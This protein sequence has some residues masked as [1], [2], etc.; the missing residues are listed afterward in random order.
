MIGGGD[1]SALRMR[2]ELSAQEESSDSLADRLRA[3]EEAQSSASAAATRSAGD[4]VLRNGECEFSHDAYD[5]SPTVGGDADQL[6]AHWLTHAAATTLLGEADAD[7]VKASGHSAYNAA[8]DDADW[9]RASGRLRLG[10]TK[11]LS[12][13]L[14]NILAQPGGILY[15]QFTATP[16][17]ATALPAGLTFYAGVWDN[18]AGQQKWVSGLALAAT[19]ANGGAA[20]ATPTQYKV[21]VDTDRGE[22]Y[23][24]VMAAPKADAPDA[25]SAVDFVTVAWPAVPGRKTSTVYRSR[26][27]V[28][29]MV[30]VINSGATSWDD[31]GDAGT[32][33]GGF[34][35]AALS[36]LRARVQDNSF[37]PQYGIVTPYRYAI[38]VP[39][40]YAVTNTQEQVLRL[41]LSAA[42]TDARQVILD[43]FQLGLNYGGFQ[44][45]PLDAPVKNRVS[46]TA[47]PTGG[48]QPASNFGDDEPPAPGEGGARRSFE[49][50]P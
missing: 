43:R 11:T 14:T 30:A 45:G 21:I 25:L 26:G 31:F 42:C 17:T 49:I 33:V 20:G 38:K 2:R 6:C 8:T 1:N 37:K 7:T 41:G 32:V 36:A 34:P 18:T 47:S 28:V 23:E 12:Q 29:S 5:N 48:L 44:R 19:A 35:A 10:S 22:Q 13:P 24:A 50:A 46:L 15:L 4:N 16:R 27:G 40:D 9:D 39:D 3:L